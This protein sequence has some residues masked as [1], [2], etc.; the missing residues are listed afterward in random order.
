LFSPHGLVLTLKSITAFCMPYTPPVFAGQHYPV[1]NGSIWTLQ[2][3]FECYIF[4]ALLGN[5]GL[6]KKPVLLAIFIA[7]V[8]IHALGGQQAALSLPRLAMFFCGGALCRLFY[9]PSAWP[10]WRRQLLL[11]GCAAA[12]LLLLFWPPL[13]LPALASFGAVL[14]FAAILTPVSALAWVNKLPDFS[15]GLYLYG[16]P[17]ERFLIW[18]FPAASPWVIFLAAWP[19]AAGLGLLSWLL[20][21]KPCLKMSKNLRRQRPF[22]A[23]AEPIG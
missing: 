4:V 13:A 11:P 21:E 14:L 6:L 19:L 17:A 23:P 7:L 16:W 15:Y 2:Y 10:A 18:Y 12:L 20:V 8:F 1:V 3:E 9:T 5:L 22:M